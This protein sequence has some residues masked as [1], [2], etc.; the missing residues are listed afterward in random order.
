MT[1]QLVIFRAFFFF[2]R[3]PN[4]KSEKKSRKSTNKKLWPYYWFHRQT[5]H[6]Q[7]SHSIIV[8]LSLTWAFTAHTHAQ[9]MKAEICTESRLSQ[10]KSFKFLNQNIC[11]YI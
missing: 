2:F 10:S 4:P 7:T 8:M 1:S 9:S 6:L 5:E 11:I 3:P